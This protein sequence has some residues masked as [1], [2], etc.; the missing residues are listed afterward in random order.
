MN[1]RQGYFNTQVSKNKNGNPDT[2]QTNDDI[3]YNIY[4]VFI[5]ADL[6]IQDDWLITAGISINNSN[7]EFK[8]LSVY[9]V[10]TQKR[11]Y[12]SEWAP[13]I[14]VLK[15]LNS[16]SSVFG[17]ISKGYS[18]PTMAELLPST[19]AINTDLE[20]EHGI[21]YELGTRLIFLK[22]KLQLEIAGFYFKI[23]NALVV[24]KDSA[25]ADYFVNAGDTRQKGIE[26]GLDYSTSF[27]TSTVFDQLIIRTAQS[28]N[29]FKYG[30]FVKDVND[31]SGKNLPG[32]PN[33]TASAIADLILKKWSL[34]QSYLLSCF[35]N[36]SK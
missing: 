1:C 22:G 33:Y 27:S 17:T 5:Q 14:T 25:N 21:N 16:T 15:K 19:G 34:F 20:A 18:P 11:E 4:S 2:L 31:F 24:R 12:Q 6:D 9:P 36:I 13:R 23:E 32:V 29:D 28:F 26:L 8:R 7:V 3:R 30:S 10:L 35:L